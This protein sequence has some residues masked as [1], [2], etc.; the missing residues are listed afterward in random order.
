M[1]GSRATVL[2][3]AL[4]LILLAAPSTATGEPAATRTIELDVLVEAHGETLYRMWTTTDGV[5]TLFPGADPLPC[6]AAPDVG[7]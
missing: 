2:S 1:N 6:R 7:P 4:S 3:C 5:C